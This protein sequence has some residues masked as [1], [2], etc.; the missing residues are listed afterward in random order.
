MHV[1][2]LSTYVPVVVKADQR[3]APEEPRVLP[4]DTSW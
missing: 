2:A 3:A 1:S 4:S